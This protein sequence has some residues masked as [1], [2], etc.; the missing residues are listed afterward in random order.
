MN[1]TNRTNKTDGRE[2]EEILAAKESFARLEILEVA[3]VVKHLLVAPRCHIELPLRNIVRWV[4]RVAERLG[5]QI[6][7]VAGM[8]LA[9][10]QEFFTPIGESI[11]TFVNIILTTEHSVKKELTTVAVIV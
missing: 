4:E 8:L 5:V 10:L 9:V 2:L 7:G 3:T 6:D 11:V 1:K